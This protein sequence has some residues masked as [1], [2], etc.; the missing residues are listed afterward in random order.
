MDN[1]D[2]RMIKLLYKKQS[3]TKVAQDLYIT[4]SAL[5]KRLQGI[6]KEWGIEVAKRTSKGVIFTGDGQYLAEKADAVLKILEEIKVHFEESAK[7]R[8]LVN[9]GMPNSF[10]RLYLSELISAYAS[11]FNEVG[12][13]TVPISSDIIVQ[14]LIDETLDI[15][16]VC[17][18][19]NFF[20]EKHKLF[21]E[22]LFLLVPHGY[23][24]H[25]QEDLPLIEGYFNPLVRRIIDQS[26]KRYFAD[27][28]KEVTNVSHIELAISMVESGLGC[29]A[30]FGKGWKYDANKVKALKI[31]DG[32]KKPVTRNIW[33]MWNN[34]HSQNPKIQTFLNFIIN[35]YNH[36]KSIG[37]K[38]KVEK[39]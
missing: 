34:K 16:I 25:K 20:G 12:I 33:L 7:I 21:A 30:L 10:A 31:Y 4:Q 2:W 27:K 39:S 6:E 17:G 1:F 8:E 32:N 38:E 15:G 23:D 18:D 37:E 29:T 13:H 36:E 24:I 5:T 11:K 26:V 35:Y 28:N 19:Y 14:K 22:E 3:L 9:F